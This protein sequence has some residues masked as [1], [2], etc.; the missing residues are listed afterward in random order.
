MRATTMRGHRPSPQRFIT[1]HVPLS[2]RVERGYR[3]RDDRAGEARNARRTHIATVLV[4]ITTL[5]AL[6]S[7]TARAD[8]VNARWSG[9]VE[10]RGNYFLERSTRVVVPTARASFVSPTGLRIGADVLLDSITSASIA[11]GAQ[12]DDLFTE[13]RWSVGASVGRSEELAPDAILDWSVFGR[14]SLENDYFA[15]AFGFDTLVALAQRCSM[16]RFNASLVSD[17]I[18]KTSDATFKEDLR[19]VSLR[20]A[21]EQILTPTITATVAA[22]VAYLDGFLA[23]AYRSVAVPGEGRLSENHPDDRWRV[24]P[25]V[26]V[27]WHIPLTRTSLHFRVRGY[28]DSWDITALTADA[29]IYQEVGEHLITRVRYR[30]YN[31]TESYF[32]DNTYRVPGTREHLVTADPKMQSF[33]TQELGLKFEWRLPFL[34]AIHLGDAWFD[35]AFDYRW[36]DNRYGDAVLAQAGMR[37]AF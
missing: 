15:T 20:F 34:R 21:Y 1:D 14:Y 28:D 6:F 23:N 22:D 7:A 16:L 11:Q 33:G 26:A 3:N 12:T 36:N 37:I 5:F 17:R 32:A 13:R 27:R 29:R 10:L 31:Q 9:D 25:S 30:S 24:A 19:G 2:T 18:E 4:A 8:E 35:T